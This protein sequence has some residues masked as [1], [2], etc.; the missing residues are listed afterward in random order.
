MPRPSTADNYVGDLLTLVGDPGKTDAFSRGLG[1]TLVANPS[2]PALL[3]LLGEVG[4]W[5]HRLAAEATTG[6]DEIK[7]AQ[8]QGAVH[9]LG[10]LI[11]AAA[12]AARTPS[13]P[14]II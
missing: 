5:E 14:S 6:A 2:R 13:S 10:E 4:A 3:E 11:E 1:R 8:I 9:V 12:D 7:T